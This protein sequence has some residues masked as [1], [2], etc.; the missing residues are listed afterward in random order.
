LSVALVPVASHVGLSP[1]IVG[2]VII[3]AGAPWL[4]VSQSLFY[5]LATEGE[6]TTPHDGTV[7]G[8]VMTF[9][10]LAAV[11]ASVP[12]WRMLGLISP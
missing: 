1:W 3:T 12:Y 2:F 10:T 4:H 5:R 11:A 8:V 7:V 9:F 6:M